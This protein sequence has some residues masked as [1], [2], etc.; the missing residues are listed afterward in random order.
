LLACYPRA[1]RREH[2]QEILSALMD[3]AREGQHRP[4]LLES[5]D[6]IKNAAWMHV[7]PGAPRPPRAVFAAVRLMYAGAALELLAL[8]TVLWTLPSLK[9]AILEREPDF[10]ATQWHAV[11]RAHVLPLE[12]GAPMAAGLLLWMAW[13]NSWGHNWGRIA[14]AALFALN[15]VSLLASVAQHSATYAPLDLAAGVVLWMVGLATLLLIFNKQSR[16]YYG[17]RPAGA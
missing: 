6:L 4:G 8:V 3:G 12:I 17:R 10:T 11:V 2:E 14:F 7:R 1:F 13:A 5:A 9:S 16:S 15:T